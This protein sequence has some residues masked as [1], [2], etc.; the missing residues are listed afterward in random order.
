VKPFG[1]CTIKK[2]YPKISV[3]TPSYNQ[4]AFIERT[5]KSVI[6]QSYDNVEYIIIDGGS[7]D[8]TLDI[9]KKYSSQINFWVS[10]KD[11]GQYDAIKKGFSLAKGEILCWLNSDDI[12]LQDSLKNVSLSF[13]KNK[14]VDVVYG[15]LYYI[16]KNDEVIR[17]MR[18]TPIIKIGYL[19]KAG[20]GLS[21]PE[22]FWK[23]DLYEKVGGINENGQF[24]M[25]YDLFFRFIKYGANFM[26]ISEHLSAL[27]FYEQTKTHNIP[28]IGRAE[29]IEIRKKLF[30]GNNQKFRALLKSLVWTIKVF[31]FL[32]QSELRYLWQQIRYKILK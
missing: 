18:N 13:Q 30:L 15:N 26:F 8:N 9:I 12:F 2:D 4:G 6:S 22:V 31:H 5:I 7:T 1:R 17:D 20:F 14:N 21:Q 10:E 29:N 27:R 19:Y 24:A 25:D 23:R 28:H 32:K 16:D 3:I 11:N